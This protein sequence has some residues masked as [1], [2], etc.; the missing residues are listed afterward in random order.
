MTENDSG[1]LVGLKNSV[2][3]HFDRLF[4]RYP[5]LS[6][7]RDGIFA[8]YNTL[9]AAYKNGHK[10]LVCGNGGS[11]ADADHIVGELMKGFNKKRTLDT[12]TATRIDNCFKG[13]IDHASRLLQGV[14]LA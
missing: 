1:S 2:K 5:Q 11:A 8:A 13:Y 7:Q 14:L 4:K 10:L 12:E 6:G 3:E 9:T